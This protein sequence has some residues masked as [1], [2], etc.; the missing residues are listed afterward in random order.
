MSSYGESLKNEN[1]L[2]NIQDL[3]YLIPVNT[4]LEQ[5]MMANF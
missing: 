4:H 1:K 2:T 5:H 3:F